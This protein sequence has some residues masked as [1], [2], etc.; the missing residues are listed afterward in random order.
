MVCSPALLNTSD[1]KC[2]MG[3]I[4]NQCISS[5]YQDD[6]WVMVFIS[7][8]TFPR[9][10]GRNALKNIVGC[11]RSPYLQDLRQIAASFIEFHIIGHVYWHKKL[12]RPGAYWRGGPRDFFG[13]E[14]LAKRVFWVYERRGGGFRSRKKYRDFLGYCTFHRLKSTIT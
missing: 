3:C 1:T 8:P 5:Q 13:S 2:D 10:P 4:L 14:I 7:S 6:P 9:S 11:K 12:H